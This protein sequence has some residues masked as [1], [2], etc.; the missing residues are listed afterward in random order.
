MLPHL[1]D[2]VIFYWGL[3]QGREGLGKMMKVELFRA[4]ECAQAVKSSELRCQHRGP[5][6]YNF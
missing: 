1:E 5:V 6:D 2:D 4:I 3:R